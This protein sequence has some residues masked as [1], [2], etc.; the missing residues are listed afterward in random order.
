MTSRLV[1]L[2]YKIYLETKNF[3]HACRLCITIA[4]F[5]NFQGFSDNIIKIKA[6]TDF[7]T[8]VAVSKKF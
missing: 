4:K 5:E 3:K 2:I 8:P 7:P 1:L 6:V